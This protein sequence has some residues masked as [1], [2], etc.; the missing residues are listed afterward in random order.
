MQYNKR[1]ATLQG[2]YAPL[3]SLYRY[4]AP[5]TGAATSAVQHI[6]AQQ[7]EISVVKAVL[8]VSEY[9]STAS[10]RSLVGP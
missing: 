5:C 6:G 10:A 7:V 1:T 2:P 9:M 4:S 3:P 8:K